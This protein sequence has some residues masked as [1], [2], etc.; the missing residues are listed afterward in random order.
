M[1]C[2]MAVCLCVVH[3]LVHQSSHVE[4][5]IAWA[6][7]FGVT[8]GFGLFLGYQVSWAVLY[9]LKGGPHA[10]MYYAP[11]PSLCWLNDMPLLSQRE[12]LE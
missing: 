3:A 2:S 1:R 6:H 10:C 8:R 4:C 5:A 12:A 11:L 7:P 9:S